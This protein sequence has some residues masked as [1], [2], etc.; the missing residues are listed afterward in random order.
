MSEETL[1]LKMQQAEDYFEYS[2]NSIELK[3]LDATDAVVDTV[4]G[5]FVFPIVSDD[6]RQIGSV[7]IKKE[8]PHFTFYSGNAGKFTPRTTRVK[9]RSS[10]FMVVEVSPDLTESTYQAGIWLARSA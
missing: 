5:I 8:N 2:P 7:E 10:I 6:S 1:D 9:I 4:K 3:I